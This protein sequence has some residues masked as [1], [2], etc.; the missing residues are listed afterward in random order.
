MLTIRLRKISPTHHSFAYTKEDGSG[1]TLELETKTYLFHD[2]LHFAVET[3]AQLANSFYGTLA[4][5]G[6]Y[7]D[8]QNMNESTEIRGEGAMT[9]KIVGA[10]TGVIKNDTP[11]EAFLDGIQNWLTATNE[12]MPTWLTEDFVLTVKEKMRKLIGEW[13]GTPFGETMELQFPY[14]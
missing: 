13:N 10:L 11:R 6:G 7:S 2:L 1:K 12:Q 3:E 5:N 14:F 4:K 8:F 9:E